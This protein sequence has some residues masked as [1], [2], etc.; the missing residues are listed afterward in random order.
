MKTSIVTI[1]VLLALA[2]GI[3]LATVTRPFTSWDQLEER[4]PDIVIAK[5][6]VTPGMAPIKE[7]VVPNELRNGLVASEINVL[8]TL[9]GGAKPGP[10]TLT[11]RYIPRQGEIY[12]IFADFSTGACEA[13]DSYQVIPLGLHFSTNDLAGKPLDEQVR[14]ALNLRLKRVREQLEG[15]QEERARLETGIKAH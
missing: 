1:A 2:A 8:S 4:S 3:A 12:L 13:L 7:G 14:E 9:K 5:C 10:S 11:S 15:L 6:L